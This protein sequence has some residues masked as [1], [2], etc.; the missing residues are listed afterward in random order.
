LRDE[1]REE[2]KHIFFFLKKNYLTRMGRSEWKGNILA[3]IWTEFLKRA[4]ILSKMKTWV[5]FIMV[6]ELKQD[7][8]L[9][10]LSD[11]VFIILI[12][13]CCIWNNL[14]NYFFSILSSFNFFYLSDLNFILLINLKKI[15]ISYF[16]AY[17]SWHNQTII[18]YF[19]LIFHNTFKYQKIIYFSKVHFPK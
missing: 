4:E 19:P 2:K 8:L 12:V 6:F 9:F 1:I 13:I 5:Q 7:I 10:Y 14:W 16:P 3:R 17:F 15:L 11:L 18:S